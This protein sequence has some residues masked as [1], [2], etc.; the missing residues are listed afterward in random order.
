MTLKIESK[1]RRR[2]DDNHLYLL[3]LLITC[4]GA[5]EHFAY[6]IYESFFLFVS[7]TSTEFII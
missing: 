2:D 1:L 5:F 4:L 7:W 6:E 3:N